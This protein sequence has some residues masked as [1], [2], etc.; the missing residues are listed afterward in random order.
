MGGPDLLE[1]C[2]RISAPTTVICGE[3]DAP[4]VGPSARLAA[5]P[6]NA[7]LVTIAGAYHS[8]QLTHPEEWTDA[9]EAHLA[10][11]G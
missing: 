11:V 1:D 8:P 7:R 10:W 3:H 2:A 5:T 4:L 6:P 9:V